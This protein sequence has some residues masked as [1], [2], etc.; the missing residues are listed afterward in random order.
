MVFS[1]FCDSRS[2]PQPSHSVLLP[3][4]SLPHTHLLHVAQHRASRKFGP[5]IILP[6]LLFRPPS[7]RPRRE[8]QFHPVIAQHF[9][10]SFSCRSW[11][12][13]G[14]QNVGKKDEALHP[15]VVEERKRKPCG[16]GINNPFK[17]LRNSISPQPEETVS[18]SAS[19]NLKELNSLP[20]GPSSFPGRNGF[21]KVRSRHYPPL[22]SISA[23]APPTH[24]RAFGLR[25]SDFGGRR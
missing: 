16:R 5:G 17:E 24:I 25:T 7:L 2:T 4:S 12:F 22:S 8:S 1:T 21:T 14:D 6:F 10:K 9:G 20:A 19:P 15:G 18:V 13:V 3:H 23:P 11:I